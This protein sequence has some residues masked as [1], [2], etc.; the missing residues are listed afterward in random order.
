MKLRAMEKPMEM[1]TELLLPAATVPANASTLA[2]ISETFSAS[3]ARSAPT[4]SLL[5]SMEALV[6]DRMAFCAIAPPPLT[7]TEV[8]LP[9]ATAIAAAQE[10]AVISPSEVADTETPPPTSTSSMSRM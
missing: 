1:P 7:A 4:L 6:E 10:L 2:S 3:T 8:P 9:A 5:S